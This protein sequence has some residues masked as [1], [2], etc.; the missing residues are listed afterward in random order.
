MLLIDDI[1]L[2]PARGILSIFQKVHEAAKQEQ[3]SDAQAITA[4]LSELYMMLETGRITEEEFNSREKSLLDRLERIR[5]SD[6]SPES[7]GDAP[8]SVRG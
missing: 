5:G 2:L 6:S 1:L 4:E 8:Q 3:A 7:G